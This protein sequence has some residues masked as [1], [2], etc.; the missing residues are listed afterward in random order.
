MERVPAGTSPRAN[1]VRPGSPPAVAAVEAAGLG[2]RFGAVVAVDGVSFRVDRGETVALLGPNGSGKTTTL[3][4]A[5]GLLRPDA[6]TV[7]VAGFD[8]RA[9][10]REARRRFTFLPQ[11]PSFAA[12][13]TAREVVAFHARLRRL[14]ADRVEAALELAGLGGDAGGRKVAELSGGMRQRLSLAVAELPEVELML[15]DEPTANLDPEAALAF[16]E[17][18]RGWRRAG[19]AL[20]L[21]THRLTD[22]QELADRVVVLVGGRP[23][24]EETIAGLRARLRRYSV[25]RV[26]LAEPAPRHREAALAAGAERA[27]LNGRSLLVQADEERRLVVLEALRAC[28]PVRGFVTEEPSLERIYLEYV[29]GR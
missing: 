27:D 13:L 19:R 28:G 6:G 20:L 1:A 10:P 8:L 12:A 23:V 22:V 29:H 3:K 7:R 24:V 26:D 15:L 14:P 4:C 9:A 21:S 18:A 25:L 2:K 11:Q 16:R 17:L 5:A